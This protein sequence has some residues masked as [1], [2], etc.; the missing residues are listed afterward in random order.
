[1][2]TWQRAAKTQRLLARQVAV[3]P[4][5]VAAAEAGASPTQLLVTIAMKMV[6]PA[7]MTKTQL[8]PPS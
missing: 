7:V 4:V 2:Q 5:V 8:P 6:E 3:P 1:M